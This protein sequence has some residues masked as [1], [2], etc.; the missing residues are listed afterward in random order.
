LYNGIEQKKPGS[1]IWKGSNI[2]SLHA[3]EQE[4]GLAPFPCSKSRPA[5]LFDVWT[6]WGENI[7]TPPLVERASEVASLSDR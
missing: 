7:F 2:L 5:Q 6:G 4:V 3:M 1:L